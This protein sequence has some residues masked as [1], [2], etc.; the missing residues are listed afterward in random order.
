M[1]NFNDIVTIEHTSTVP[2]E[3]AGFNQGNLATQKQQDRKRI[4]GLMD[5]SAECR[6]LIR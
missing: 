3:P 2:R 5:S 4:D 6:P 1:E